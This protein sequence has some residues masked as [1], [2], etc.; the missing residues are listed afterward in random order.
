M[1]DSDLW[2]YRHIEIFILDDFTKS[3]VSR[4]LI[5]SASDRRFFTLLIPLPSVCQPPALSVT[6]SRYCFILKRV[7]Q[8]TCCDA[9]FLC[10]D[11]EVPR[12]GL[13]SLHT[14]QQRWCVWKWLSL[15]SKSPKERVGDTDPL[16]LKKKLGRKWII[17]KFAIPLVYDLG[18]EN[19]LT[20]L[21]F[22][23]FHL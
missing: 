23:F 1:L 11:T 2:C 13:C 15:T 12:G 18:K 8:G 16:V 17:W 3:K 19:H 10:D 9:H 14:S 21:C 22:G 4:L 7:M 20:S 6:Y 5:F